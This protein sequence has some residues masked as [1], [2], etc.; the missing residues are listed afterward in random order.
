M[1]IFI[2][3]RQAHKKFVAKPQ[4]KKIK[5]LLKKKIKINLWFKKK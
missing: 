5:N 3:E 1:F 4:T 2:I